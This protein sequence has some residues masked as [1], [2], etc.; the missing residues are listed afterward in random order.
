MK[1]PL[2]ESVA[3]LNENDLLKIAEIIKKLSFAI[4][5]CSSWQNAQATSGGIHA[6]EIDDSLRLKK[7]KGIY[8]A[9]EI[10][11]TDGKCG[12]YNLEWAWSSGR[13]AGRNCANSMNNLT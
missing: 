1:L 3:V 10:L 2:T 4:T 11:D 13:W 7:D 8:F 5:G 9:G 6:D 12:G